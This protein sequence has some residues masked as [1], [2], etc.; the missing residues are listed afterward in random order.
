MEHKGLQALYNTDLRASSVD[1]LI[2]VAFHRS[3]EA[4][5]TQS[6]AKHIHQQDNSLM[7]CL[8]TALQPNFP[9]M[10]EHGQ[11]SSSFDDT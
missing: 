11:I 9:L 2:S 3:L 5:C 4:G 6:H 1:A 10:L 8:Y 7:F